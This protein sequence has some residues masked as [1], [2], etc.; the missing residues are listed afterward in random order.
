MDPLLQAVLYSGLAPSII[1]VAI[2]GAVLS[3]KGAGAWLG[4]ALACGYAVS[5]YL[6]AGLPDV[7]PHDTTDGLILT[8]GVAALVAATGLTER[9]GTGRSLITFAF[10]AAASFWLAAFPFF[11]QDGAL[12]GAS[13]Y[14]GLTVAAWVCVLFATDA[15][16]QRL[17]VPV[18]GMAWTIGGIAASVAGVLAFSALYGQLAGGLSASAGALTAWLWWRRHPVARPMAAVYACLHPA[19]LV[20][21]TLWADLPVSAALLVLVS[22][23]A[24]ALLLITK[25][26]STF[27]ALVQAFLAAGLPAAG[28]LWIAYDNWVALGGGSDLYG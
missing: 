6:F 22:P 7:P 8:A 2:G 3:R 5:H 16:S 27:S 4:V 9:A 24:I 20:N 21:A 10:L 13:G 25:P 26:K 15:L 18:V 14:L 23:L 11:R 17:P 1:A 19:F 12:E 28:G